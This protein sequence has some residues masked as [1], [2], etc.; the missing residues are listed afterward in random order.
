MTS[1]L[2]IKSTYAGE[3]TSRLRWRIRAARQGSRFEDRA[4]HRNRRRVVVG[5]FPTHGDAGRLHDV[6]VDDELR[7]TGLVADRRGY[8]YTTDDPATGSPW[9]AMPDVFARLPAWLRPLEFIADDTL[10]F[11]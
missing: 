9:L 5:A 1:D 3:P 11:V 2:L 6:G 8:G 4:A 7:R 10:P